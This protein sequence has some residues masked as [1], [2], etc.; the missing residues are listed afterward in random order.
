SPPRRGPAAARTASLEMDQTADPS[1]DGHRGGCRPGPQTPTP[2]GRQESDSRPRNGRPS[3]EPDTYSTCRRPPGG[4]APP[5]GSPPCRTLPELP[6][7]PP[8]ERSCSGTTVSH[9]G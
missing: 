1:P 7:T 8:F 4:L 2:D 9:Q 5:D 6:R 3:P